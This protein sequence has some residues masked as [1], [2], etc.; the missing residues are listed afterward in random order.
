MQIVQCIK[1]A[2]QRLKTYIWYPYI[3][4]CKANIGH[5]GYIYIYMYIYIYSGSNACKHSA[6]NIY[7]YISLNLGA[8]G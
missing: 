5:I 3:Y 8:Q 1:N 4:V 6:A 7:I 2:K